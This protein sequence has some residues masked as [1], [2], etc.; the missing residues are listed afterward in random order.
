MHPIILKLR[1]IDP[2]WLFK[3]LGKSGIA[4]VLVAIPLL[5]FHHVGYRIGVDMVKGD[6]CLPFTFYLYQPGNFS[7]EK[8]AYFAFKARRMQPYYDD[9]LIIIKEIVGVPGDKVR[10]DSKVYVNDVY[11]GD[12]PHIKKLKKTVSDFAR[13]EIVPP[14]KFWVM[15]THPRSF[16]SRYWGYVDHAQIIGK[17]YAL[18]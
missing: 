12:L 14:E 7:V 17:A 11:R 8:G 1:S 18:W 6:S 5:A 2:V 10:V 15:G 3:G 4:L 16:D 13:N 9:D